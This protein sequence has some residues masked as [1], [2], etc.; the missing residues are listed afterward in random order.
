MT[1]ASCDDGQQHLITTVFRNRD[2]VTLVS[3][4]KLAFG[5]SISLTT[6][7]CPRCAKAAEPTNDT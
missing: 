2:G 7:T 3:A 5:P 1:W 6:R 4:C